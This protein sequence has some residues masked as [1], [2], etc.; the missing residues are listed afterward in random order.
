MIRIFVLLIC[1]QCAL[2]FAQNSGELPK[3]KAIEK[4]DCT[5]APGFSYA[6][7]LPS[8]YTS[9]KSWPVLFIF[10]AE[11]K[12]MVP[13]EL[14]KSGAEK[15]GYIIV[16]SN[17]SASDDPTVPNW[18]AMVAMY[19]DATSRFSLNKQRMYSAGYSGGA[20][21]AC[22]MAYRYSGQ[23]AGV[24]GAGSGFP[25]DHDPTPDTPFAFFATV[26]NLDFNYYE[27]RL[28]EPKLKSAGIPYRIRVFDG[29]HDWPP[30]ELCIEE[31]EWMEIQA[32]KSGKREKDPALIEE[33]FQKRMKRAEERK[34]SGVL[35]EGAE[36][37]QSIAT[38][39]KSLRDV[40]AVSADATRL[41][42]SEQV[43]KWQQEEARR[44]QIDSDFRQKLASVNRSIRNTSDKVPKLQNV[45]E[46]LQVAEL[47]KKAKEAS[48][49]EDRLQAQRLLTVVAI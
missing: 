44:D 38:D 24:I 19:N 42:E 31:L 43:K 10:D 40:E 14:F 36:E 9:E 1:L 29:E 22:D 11:A 18:Q 4:V 26:G 35:H 46:F 27:M 37:Y 12:G 45:L 33:I 8:A 25:T 41:F 20:R 2:L 13:L 3:G 17:N 7:Y 48:L 23:F 6:L 39:F 5:G 15:Y 49:K 28:L 30:A 34:A 16:S 21:I 47:K 32:M